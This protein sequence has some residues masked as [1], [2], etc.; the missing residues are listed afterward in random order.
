MCVLVCVIRRT[1]LTSAYDPL[2]VSMVLT[3]RKLVSLAVSVVAFSNTF[4]M[5]H[6]VGTTVVFVGALGFTAESHYA[7]LRTA[8]QQQQQ[9]DQEGA[10]PAVAGGDTSKKTY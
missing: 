6:I 1:Q 3:V 10:L 5:F 7:R 2:T 8:Q 4:T 9:K